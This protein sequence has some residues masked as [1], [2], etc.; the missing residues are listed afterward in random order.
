MWLS[1]V[2]NAVLLPV[3]M[4]LMLRLAND[5]GLMKGWRNTRL[6]NILAIVLA[7]L[8]TIATGS[9]FVSGSQ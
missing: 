2:A 1:Q 9:L 4:V 5:T 8:V 3:V 6:T 7:V